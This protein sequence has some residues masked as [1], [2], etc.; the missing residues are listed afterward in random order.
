MK[1]LFSNFL[2]LILIIIWSYT[3]IVTKVAL[4]YIDPFELSL[5]RTL[6]GAMFL[7]VIVLSL[8]KL[9]MPKNI[10]LIIILGFLQNSLLM[11][12]YNVALVQGG[13]GKVVLLIYS[14]PFW[15]ILFSVM[16]LKEKLS[17]LQKISF[18]LALIGLIFI[19]QLWTS[20][21]NLLSYVAALLG[22]LSWAAANIVAVFIWRSK[23]KIDGITLSFWQM[24]FGFLGVF[25]FSFFVKISKPIEVNLTLVLALFFIGVLATGFA[26]FLWLYLLKNISPSVLGLTSLLVPIFSILEAWYHLGEVPGKYEIIGIFLILAALVLIYLNSLIK[27]RRTRV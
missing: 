14:M 25:F 8:K 27:I 10:W 17:I 12:F 6:I 9:T 23:E 16:F 18:V 13:A 11:I 15:T 3:A 7:F 22:G 19:L 24:L 21:S 5:L 4:L 1:N 26:W 2:F 20:N